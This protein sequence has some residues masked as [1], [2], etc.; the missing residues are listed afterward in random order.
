MSCL[1]PQNSTE[2]TALF[3]YLV[4]FG[5]GAGD[6]LSVDGGSVARPRNSSPGGAVPTVV[7]VRSASRA[8]TSL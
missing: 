3:L 7:L 6:S 2:A 1:P 8:R 5:T 4:H